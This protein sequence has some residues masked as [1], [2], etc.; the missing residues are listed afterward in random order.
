MLEV[1]SHMN[2]LP[3]LTTFNVNGDPSKLSTRWKRWVKSL[4]IYIVAVN[5]KDNN[6]KKALLLHFLGEDGQ[7][8]YDT[9]KEIEPPTNQYE[10]AIEKLNAFFLPKKNIPYERHLFNSLKQNS[11]ETIGAYC[12]RLRIAAKTCE[13]GTLEDEMI[14]D[15]IIQTCSSA[16]LRRKLLQEARLTL[17]ILLDIAQNMELSSS[18]AAEIEKSKFTE[19]QSEQ[20]NKLYF[21][22]DRKFSQQ[23][24]G[25]QSNEQSS[26]ECY[27]CGRIGHFAKSSDCPARKV[28]CRKCGKEGHFEKVCRSQIKRSQQDRAKKINEIN[29]VTEECSSE[30]DYLFTVTSD[31]KLQHAEI[32]ID[33][34]SVKFVID[35]GASVNIIDRNTW[36]N[37]GAE[38]QNSKAR[39]LPYGSDAPLELLGQFQATLQLNDNIVQSKVYVINKEDSGLF[40]RKRLSFEVTNSS[41]GRENRSGE[42][43]FERNRR[44]TACK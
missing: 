2:G 7:D 27:R 25:T 32:T 21:Q 5:I 28:K 33:G 22:R 9:I 40:V 16:R 23:S 20:I 3:G 43:C 10:H 34:K 26:K 13:F 11:N 6:R 39:L 4:E 42:S 38:L 18:Q 44:Y 41:T 37:I 17:E 12:S 30:E 14:R 1:T 24:G 36:R 8:L 29:E 19:S 31:E 35:T 15:H